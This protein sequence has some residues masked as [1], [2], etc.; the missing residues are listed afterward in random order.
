MPYNILVV[1]DS[2]VTRAV[3]EKTLT[4]SGLDVEKIHHAGNGQEAL[5]TLNSNW[6]DIVLA[7]INMPVMNGMELVDQMAARNILATTPVVIIST[8]RSVTRIESLKS[9]GISAYLAK[10]FTPE[11]VKEVVEQALGE[12]RPEAEV[13]TL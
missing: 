4:L 8:E 12:E 3:I 11:S 1:D 6:I 5:D 9:K 2:R 13:C 10:P 7:D